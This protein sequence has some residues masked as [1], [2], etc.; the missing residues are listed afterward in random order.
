[1]ALALLLGAVVASG[2]SGS[3]SESYPDVNVSKPD[4]AGGPALSLAEW[5]EGVGRI[6]R[7]AAA[8][9]GGASNELARE[10]KS[11]DGSIDEGEISRRAFELAKPVFEE[12]LQ[13]LAK[14]QPPAELAEAY[15]GFIDNLAEEL[16][17][18]GRVAGMLGTD[19]SDEAMQNADDELAE[20]AMDAAHFVRENRLAGCLVAAPGTR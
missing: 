7:Q 12:Q 3:R 13:E 18:T 8:A 15:Q 9:V 6:C 17:W 20:S 4:L 1:V 10:I 19:A 11:G 14:L 16:Q 2:C 5:R